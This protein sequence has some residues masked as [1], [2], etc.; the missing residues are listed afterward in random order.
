MGL[1][2]KCEGVSHGRFFFVKVYF[3]GGFL[4]LCVVYPNFSEAFRM[5]PHLD[6]IG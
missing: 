1:M 2:R 6:Q 4:H 3:L 5:S